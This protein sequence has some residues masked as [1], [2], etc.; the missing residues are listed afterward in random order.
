MADTDRRQRDV[1][2]ITPDQMRDGIV[3]LNAAKIQA[4]SNRF[5]KELDAESA[6]WERVRDQLTAVMVA[7]E[8]SDFSIIWATMRALLEVLTDGDTSVE[9]AKKRIVMCLNV[10]R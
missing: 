9:E 8:L 4:K 3:D 7:S 10:F 1:E 6:H 2:I 5:Q